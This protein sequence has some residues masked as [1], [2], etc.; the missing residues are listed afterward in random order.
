MEQDKKSGNND[1]NLGKQ[2]GSIGCL[3]C[4]RAESITSLPWQ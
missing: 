2:P 1:T 3:I 4:A